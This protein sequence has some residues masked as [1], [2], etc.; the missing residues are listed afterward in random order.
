M[1]ATL[2]SEPRLGGGSE[3]GD[4]RRGGRGQ[5]VVE[6]VTPPRRRLHRRCPCRRWTVVVGGGGGDEGGQVVVAMTTTTARER[7]RERNGKGS[8]PRG[9]PDLPIRGPWPNP[10]PPFLG[11][12]PLAV[13]TARADTDRWM[14]GRTAQMMCA[15]LLRWLG[16]QLQAVADPGWLPRRLVGFLLLRRAPRRRRRGDGRAA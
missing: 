12:G 10:V 9:S 16:T 1:V 7:E 15:G 8:G 4:G 2:G 13:V 3:G 5:V 11:L 14:K 6:E